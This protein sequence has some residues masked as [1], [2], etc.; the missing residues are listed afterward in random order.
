[1]RGKIN[2][3]V[4]C[5]ATTAKAW[6]LRAPQNRVRAQLRIMTLRPGWQALAFLGSQSWSRDADPLPPHDGVRDSAPSPTCIPRGATMPHS[7]RET[8][9]QL[10]S[11][12]KSLG[13]SPLAPTN[14]SPSLTRRLDRERLEG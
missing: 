14:S 12:V 11:R 4:N 6:V 9:G 8:P 7:H 1:M 2:H 13:S 3:L 10:G 5:L